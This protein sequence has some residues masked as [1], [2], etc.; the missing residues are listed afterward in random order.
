M[1]D[2]LRAV[3]R[4]GDVCARY[5]GDEFVLL[6]R[7]P[8]QFA[9]LAHAS[10]MA[11]AVIAVLRE[12]ILIDGLRFH[13]SC[14]VGIADSALHGATAQA[15]VTCADI[16]MYEAKSLGK[17]QYVPYS[18]PLGMRQQLRSQLHSGLRV[19]LE[20]LEI[21]VH[22][23]ARLDCKTR[24]I[25]AAEALARWTL[26][27][28]NEISPIDF[29]ATA[30]ETGLIHELGEYVLRQ[31][32]ALAVEANRAQPSKEFVVSVNL[33]TV[34]L[35]QPQFVERVRTVF[36]Q[37]GCASQWI[38]F[39]VTESRG[40][41]D[42]ACLARLDTLVKEMGVRC[43]LDDFGTG[44]SNMHELT[45]LPI[46][47]VKIDRSFVSQAQASNAIVVA[48]VVAIAG[49]LNIEVVAEGVETQQQYEQITAMGCHQFQ[50]FL[51]SK[52]MPHA[53]F[54]QLLEDER[55]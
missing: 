26:S 47:A 6:V 38:E 32:C 18:E 16:A 9:T 28:G 55:T 20:N 14:S 35:H 11:E 27:D 46:T 29:I 37:T 40:L 54:L 30:E 2:R 24:T 8:E 42:P 45:R 15:L 12:P 1:A 21:H 49:S 22:F 31:A 25:V 41:T 5:G 39:E 43:A 48:A 51:H 19:A 53:A 13:I 36:S 33:S 7:T 52:A 10:R 4:V 50:G 23:Q 3:V 17:D 44:Y 34:Q